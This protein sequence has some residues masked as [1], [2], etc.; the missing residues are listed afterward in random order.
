MNLRELEFSVVDK[1]GYRAAVLAR[2]WTVIEG[3]LLG[4]G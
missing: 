3:K 1:N 4:K 2:P